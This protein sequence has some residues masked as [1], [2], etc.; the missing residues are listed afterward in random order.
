[1]IS[2][3]RLEAYST[4]L[5]VPVRH[6]HFGGA[7]LATPRSCKQL[8][9]KIFGLARLKLKM[10]RNK[11]F[12]NSPLQKAAEFSGVA[13]EFR[14]LSLHRS[15]ICKGFVSDAGWLVKLGKYSEDA[16]T[17]QWFF[18]LRTDL[19]RERMLPPALTNLR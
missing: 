8:P 1:M 9:S 2:R 17:E 19:N 5:A 6:R 16:I 14:C 10:D 15:Q 18:G 13:G 7:L 11:L 4:L 12:S 3:Y